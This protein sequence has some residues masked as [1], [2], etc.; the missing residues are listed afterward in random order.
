MLRE[1]QY[2]YQ[3]PISLEIPH[4]YGSRVHLIASPYAQALLRRFSSEG[5]DPAWLPL[6]VD[7]LYSILLESSMSR[8]LPRKEQR[9]R[10]PMAQFH[11]E[12]EFKGNWISPETKVVV[13]APVRAGAG[14]ALR[15]YQ[16][17]LAILNPE[18]VRLDYVLASREINKDGHVTG[19]KIEM[20]TGGPVDGYIG[21]LPDPML[22]TGST[23]RAIARAYEAH[24]K[25]FRW[26][27]LHLIV[28]PESIEALAESPFEIFAFRVDRGLSS[29]EALQTIP[30]TDRKGEKGLNE[31]GYL[32]PGAGGVGERLTGAMS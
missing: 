1:S 9:C 17:L 25:I 15:C 27:G 20:K 14:P 28:S 12:G 7:R 6:W 30:G 21:L 24:G 18:S 26:I 3:G 10:T 5:A 31:K 16:D 22:A 29:Q 2:D 8:V 11:A 32:I 23:A 13:V 4:H 19:A